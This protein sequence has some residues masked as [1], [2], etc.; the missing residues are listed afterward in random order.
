M[1]ILFGIGGKPVPWSLNSL[2]PKSILTGAKLIL[3]SRYV[4]DNDDN[5][6]NYTSYT[7]LLCSIV[8]VQMR[9]LFPMPCR[10]H[11]KIAFMED[12]ICP[13][14]TIWSWFGNCRVWYNN[15]TPITKIP[16]KT[17]FAI[18]FSA[19]RGQ[20]AMYLNLFPAQTSVY[21]GPLPWPLCGPLSPQLQQP[22]S[23]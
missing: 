20:L 16:L 13:F 17:N 22:P 10:E 12:P 21:A 9:S 6:K 2:T 4:L 3:F 5:T 18:V 8:L 14:D 15:T 23:H 7:I 1:S 11:S 19:R